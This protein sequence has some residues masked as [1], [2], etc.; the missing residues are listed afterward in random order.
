MNAVLPPPEER[1]H[2]KTAI[3]AARAERTCSSPA[4]SS[5]ESTGSSAS[6]ARAAWAS[7]S[8]RRTSQLDQRVALKFLLPDAAERAEARRRASCA[9]RAPRSQLKSEHVARVLDVGTLDDG[10]PYIVMEYLEGCDL[11][12]RSRRARPL[13]ID[14]AV[15]YVLQ[16]C[17]AL[18][19]AHAL[20]IVHRDLK[21]ANLFLTQRA[22]G[23]PLVKVLDFGIS[24]ASSR[25]AERARALTQHDDA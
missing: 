7:S 2:V 25:T 17:E 11:G 19:E 5:R 22:D 9:R 1:L 14:E 6:S 10:A 15:D 18:A 12:R 16:A 23:T 20:G 21:P 3:G 13:P 24:K 4:T 8:R